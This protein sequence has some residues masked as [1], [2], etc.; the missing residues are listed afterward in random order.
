MAQ[1][2]GDPDGDVGVGR[3]KVLGI[4]VFRAYPIAAARHLP[5]EGRRVIEPAESQGESAPL[6]GEL[7]SGA[8]LRGRSHASMEVKPSKH[9]VFRAYPTAAARHLP[10]EGR[11]VI[12]GVEFME[13]EIEFYGGLRRRAGTRMITLRLESAEPTV[14]DAVAALHEELPALKGALGSVARAVDDVIVGDDHRLSEGQAL[15]LLPPVSGGSPRKYLAGEPL[16]RDALIDATADDSCGALVVFS[17]DVR[18]HNAGRDDV[19]AI[20]YEAHDAIAARV[21]SQIEGEVLEGFDVRQCRVQHRVG[22]V[23]L[24]ESTVLVVCRAAHRDAAFKG[25]R[26]AIDE[27]KTRAPLWKCEIYADGE[28]RYLD[29]I[30]LRKES[31]Q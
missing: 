31:D 21:L 3:V 9:A 1:W 7:A 10:W 24:G 6:L 30:S 26:Y 15:A 25:A 14:A 27:L 23:E 17:G 19:V 11:G 18:N 8:R 2:A 5:W 4:G 20:E 16:D 28:S 13:I 22:R 12:E 29:G